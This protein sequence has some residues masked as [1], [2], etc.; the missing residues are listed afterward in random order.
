MN[1]Q[2]LN[3]I[4]F[5][6]VDRKQEQIMLV[7]EAN[8]WT[9]IS[10]QDF[11]RNVAGMVRA[12]DHWG[13][14]KGDRIAILSENRPEWAVADFA[15]FLLGAVVVPLYPTLTAEQ[16]AYILR[17]SGAKIAVVSTQTQLEKIVSIKNQS[18]FERVVV[19]DPVE[20]AQATLMQRLM[21]QGPAGR[22]SELEARARKVTADD[23]ASII[24]T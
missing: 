21:H 7:R 19:M 10:S 18:G 17:D 20:T 15:S 3:D 12:L 8:Q 14:N 24:Y 16:S 11:Y 13:V 5:A 6:I 2:T 22:D 23:L 9:P 1:P 4:F